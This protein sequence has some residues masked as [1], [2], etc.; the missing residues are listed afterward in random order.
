MDKQALGL[1]EKSGVSWVSMDPSG[2]FSEE[3]SLAELRGPD[4][5]GNR[6][7]R[8]GEISAWA[9]A[10]SVPGFSL[11][12]AVCV[13]DLVAIPKCI[14]AGEVPTVLCSSANGHASRVVST[15]PAARNY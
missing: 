12:R 7:G 13:P 8:H 3:L 15:C 6:S 14:A 5:T 4:G 10:N 1:A 9:R 11:E 2:Q